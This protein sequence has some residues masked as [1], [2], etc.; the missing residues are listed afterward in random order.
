MST[1]GIEIDQDEIVLTRGRDFRWSFENLD[2]NNQP[3]P[4][5]AGDLYFELLTGGETNCVQQ[6]EILQASD[7]DYRLGYDG[8]WS[9]DIEYY[10][11]DDSLYDLTID[12]R[13]ALE[14][15]PA[16]GAGNVAVSRTGL[17]PVWNLHFTLTG[18][19][20]NEI[21][22]LSV[23]NLLGWLGQQLGEGQMVLSYRDTDAD[24]PI[25]FEA[26][27][28]TIQAAL[29]TIPQLGVGNVT[30]TSAGNGLFNIEYKNLLA[31]RDVDQIKVRAYEK[32]AGDFFGGGITGNLLTVLSTKTIQNGRRAVLDGR[33]MS[34]LTQK[35]NDFFSL[36]DDRL[37][38]QTSFIIRSNTDFTMV[39]KATKGYEE[40]DLVTFDVVF[41][42]AMLKQYLSNQI[43]LAGAIGTTAVDLYW[44]HSYAVEFVN[45]L[46]NRPHPLL[47][48][49]SSGLTNSITKFSLPPKIRTTFIERGQRAITTWPFIV[50]DTMAHLKIESEDA[51]RIGNRTR[52]QLVFLPEGEDA[53]G[54]PI[55]RGTVT[56]QR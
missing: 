21:Q 31:A 27:A 53:G 47:V 43:L 3:T 37:P 42:A 51:D 16:I 12:V 28:Q 19:S 33:M 36:F 48:G 7:G 54:E 35:V 18:T 2:E 29:E 44:N 6:V 11:A 13:S 45:E 50:E 9:D 23:V 8:V 25:S 41:S 30:V 26:N 14:N 52:W 55:A 34:T 4:Y 17:N 24:Y 15:I 38:I 22:Q 49:D 32:N 1:I 5:P 46:A 56:E 40:I 39:C 20:Q 10:R